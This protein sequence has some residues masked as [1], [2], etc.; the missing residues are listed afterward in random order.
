MKQVLLPILAATAFIVIV[1]V[2]FGNPQKGT[3][4]F[5][6][7]TPT[8]VTSSQKT[9]QVGSVSLKIKLANT[10]EARSK[11]LSG[12]SSLP[13]DEGMLFIFDQK[14]TTPAFWMKD[15]LIPLDIIWIKD[16]KVSQIDKNIQPPD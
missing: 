8:S 6:N 7:P 2:L 10:D 15:M 11:G 13:A 16:S 9:I 5:Q 12:I 4:L 1:G 3:N 14:G